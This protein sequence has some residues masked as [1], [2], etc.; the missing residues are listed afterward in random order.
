[1]SDFT[2]IKIMCM[3]NRHLS[4][5][6]YDSQISQIAQA[7]P[8]AVIV[9]EKDLPEQEYEMLAARVMDICARYKVLCIPH[10]YADAAI[11]L[12]AAAL[13]L[14]LPLLLSMSKEQKKQFS[15]LG[16][17]VHSKNEA[18]QAKKAGATYLTAGHIFA[19][20]CKRGVPPKGL[21]VLQE[22]CKS[23]PQ[24]PVYAL[25][26]INAQNAPSCIRA[27]AYGVCIMSECMRYENVQD[28]FKDYDMPSMIK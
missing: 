28:R 11:R 7:R 26:G 2:K 10:T 18:L 21:S 15:I 27:G 5:R 22:I 12:G 19:T 20:D 3:T 16:A 24:L 8:E 14:P 4:V 6:D 17:S 9:R 23:V 1:M 25:G 13:H